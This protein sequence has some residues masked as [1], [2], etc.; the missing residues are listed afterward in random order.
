MYSWDDQKSTLFACLAFKISLKWPRVLAFQ[1]FWCIIG[2]T[3]KSCKNNICIWSRLM[4]LP[5]NSTHNSWPV[6]AVILVSVSHTG[7]FQAY[8]LV[9]SSYQWLDGQLFTCKCL[10]SWDLLLF[11]FVGSFHLFPMLLLS[12]SAFIDKWLTKWIRNWNSTGSNRACPNL[13]NLFILVY[14][15]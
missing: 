10:H 5:I 7:H 15:G 2:R 3:D 13:L 6:C 12:G 11:G 4:D 8:T 9:H 1:T 14:E